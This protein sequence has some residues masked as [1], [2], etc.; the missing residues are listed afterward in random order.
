MKPSDTNDERN[1]PVW[2]LLSSAR[3][4]EASPAFVQNTLRQ[5]RQTHQFGPAGSTA[6][7][8]WSRFLNLLRRPAFAL[9]LAATALVTVAM[10]INT[11]TP[12]STLEGGL[13]A[14]SNSSDQGTSSTGLIEAPAAAIAPAIAA[15]F[16]FT[17]RV[18]EIDN[19]GDLVVVTDPSSLNEQ[20]LA[21]LFY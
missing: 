3:K 18:K 2:E 6:G 8:A 17:D 10:I 5:A 15:E 21:N 14:N 7:C 12:L 13:A 19:L 9:P 1:D 16:S 20:M 11:S 4:T